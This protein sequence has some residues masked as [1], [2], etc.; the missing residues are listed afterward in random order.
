MVRVTNKSNTK[1]P[2]HPASVEQVLC[3]DPIV[4]MTVKPATPQVH[5]IIQLRVSHSTLMVVLFSRVV[6]QRTGPYG[7]VL[8]KQPEP[9]KVS[10]VH[11]HIQNNIIVS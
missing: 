7:E 11:H 9:P 2:R 10:Q 5:L 3:P 1:E 8:E 4:G 6:I